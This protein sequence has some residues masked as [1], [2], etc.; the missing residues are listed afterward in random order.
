MTSA[1]D[2]HFRIIPKR[3]DLMGHFRFVLTA[4]SYAR[5]KPSPEPYLLALKRLEM[6]AEQCVVIE[7][8][9][10]GLQAALAA[11]IRCIVLRSSMTT[12]YDFPGAFRVVD[13]MPELLAEVK[14]LL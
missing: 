8:S 11:S 12:H 1:S 2:E 7:D 6:P 9:P 3:L 4:E 14:S 13:T 5:S 10:R